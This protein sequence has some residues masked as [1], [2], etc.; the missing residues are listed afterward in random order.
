M[1]EKWAKNAGTE[2][3]RRVRR[4]RGTAG[5]SNTVESED[6]EGETGPDMAVQRQELKSASDSNVSHA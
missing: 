4:E 3:F 2:T 6:M 5:A 1:G